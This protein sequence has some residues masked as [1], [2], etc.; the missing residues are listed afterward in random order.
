[1][2]T[3]KCAH[4]ACVDAVL[5]RGFEDHVIHTLEHLTKETRAMTDQLAGLQAA[6]AA[7]GAS[8][9]AEGAAVAALA[10]QQSTFLGDVKLALAGLGN[11]D[12]VTAI[13]NDLNTR[14]AQLDA[15]GAQVTQLAADQAAA[16]PET[17]PAAPVADVPA[18]D[19]VPAA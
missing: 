5:S 1:M 4:N 16:D 17:A 10:A 8:V 18:T 2:T 11:N 14:Q 13:I 19:P 6:D 7:L 3:W 12:Q 15:I 9:D